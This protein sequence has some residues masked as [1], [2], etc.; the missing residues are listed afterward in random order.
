MNR[1]PITPCFSLTQALLSLLRRRGV[2]EL[3]S[4]GDLSA[5]ESLRRAI[6]DPLTWRYLRGWA[7]ISDL[8]SKLRCWLIE[9]ASSDDTAADKLALWRVLASAELE[10]YLAHLLRRHGLSPQW[11]VDIDDSGAYWDS[12]LSLAQMRYVVWASVREGAGAFLR[13]GGNQ[14]RTRDAIANELRRRSRWIEGHVDF[15][16]RFLPAPGARRSILLT[17]FLEDVA[18]LGPRYWL[19]APSLASLRDL[20]PYRSKRR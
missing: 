4:D 2:L 3:C 10:G 11:A 5:P 12:G 17:T 6:Y 13:S 8:E 20:A 7:H 9:L 14:E 18:P 15:G 19:I 1:A 16:Q